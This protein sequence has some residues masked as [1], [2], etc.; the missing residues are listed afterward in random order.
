M[1]IFEKY[2][3]FDR[4]M[5]HNP[6]DLDTKI[7]NLKKIL[8]VSHSNLDITG[9]SWDGKMGSK[10]FGLKCNI[11][12]IPKKTWEPYLNN[13]LKGCNCSSCGNDSTASRQRNDFIGKSKTKHG[14]NRFDYS[15]CV[16]KKCKEKVILICIKHRE[17]FTCTPPE[18]LTS[19]WGCCPSCRKENTSGENHVLAV[20]LEELKERIRIIWG[21]RFKYDFTGYTCLGDTIKITCDE[22]NRS[23]SSTAT[24]HISQ[25]TPKGCITCGRKVCADK[26]R[27]PL[28][29]FIKRAILKHNNKYTYTNVIYTK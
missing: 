6:L 20:T 18:H 4:E 1:N 25:P 28:E 7:S 15:K 9:L 3:Q 16:Y 5:L 22:C 8:K 17:E 27:M 11:H 12:P 13:L 19:E 14:E 10:I 24:N 2:P 29:E 23:W 21:D 26:L